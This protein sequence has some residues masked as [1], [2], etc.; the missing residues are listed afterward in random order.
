MENYGTGN[1]GNTAGHSGNQ[2][3]K[4]YPKYLTV[5]QHLQVVNQSLKYVLKA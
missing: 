4:T 3:F 1:S 5:C 2:V